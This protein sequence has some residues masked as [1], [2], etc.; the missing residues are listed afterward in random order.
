VKKIDGRT[1]RRLCVRPHC[2]VRIVF[3][4]FSTLTAIALVGCAHHRSESLS[5]SGHTIL[6]KGES[7]T[8]LNAFANNSASNRADRARA[9][10]KLFAHHIRPGASAAEVHSVLA[11]TNWMGDVNLYRVYVPPDFLPVE[12]TSE[13]TVFCLH[14]FPLVEM[15][16]L[17]SPW[18]I[19]FRLSGLP[20]EGSGRNPEEAMAFLRGDTTLYGRPRLIEFALCYPS[21]PAASYPSAQAM[22]TARIER[23]SRRGIRVYERD[24]AGRF[25]SMSVIDEMRSNMIGGRRFSATPPSSSD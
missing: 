1:R 22:L 8:A 11:D 19:Y 23:F 3:I 17:S 21:D 15:D 13:D 9:I 18:F 20:R 14:L 7:V 25:T 6:P 2:T 12:M 5:S 16:K 4:I 10:F 24:I